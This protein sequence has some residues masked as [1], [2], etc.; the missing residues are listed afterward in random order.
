MVA[1]QFTFEQIDED[2]VA[3]IS[4]HGD[5]VGTID[6]SDPDNKITTNEGQMKAEIT[7]IGTDETHYYDVRVGDECLAAFKQSADEYK[8]SWSDGQKSLKQCTAV[9]KAL[10]TLTSQWKN[11]PEL[12]VEIGLKR[13]INGG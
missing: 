8:V 1:E 3:I 4:T 2:R 10:M 9:L 12:N 7:R 13:E 5:H 11:D 6:R